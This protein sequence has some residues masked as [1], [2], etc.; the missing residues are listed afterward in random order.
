MTSIPTPQKPSMVLAYHVGGMMFRRIS[1]LLGAAALVSAGTI[2]LNAQAPAQPPQGAAAATPPADEH[3][4]ASPN[5]VSIHLDLDVNRPAADVW[6]RIGK[7]CD[8]GEW[9]Q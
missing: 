5:Y 4:S 6:K 2:A 1:T 9:F 3:V 8:I 7:Y